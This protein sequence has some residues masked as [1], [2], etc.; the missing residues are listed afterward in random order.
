[1]VVHLVLC[2]VRVVLMHVKFCR[3]GTS[4][5]KSVASC[6]TFEG[7]NVCHDSIDLNVSRRFFSEFLSCTFKMAR[8]ATNRH[9]ISRLVAS[10]LKRLSLNLV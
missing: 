6:M 2:D 8:P 10:Y 9:F 4:G 3:F 1:M 7:V 5:A